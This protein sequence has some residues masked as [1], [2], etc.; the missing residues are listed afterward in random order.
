MMQEVFVRV[1]RN[2]DDFREDASP[3]TW[4]YRI[5]TNLCLNQIRDRKRQQEKLR[6]KGA[7]PAVDTSNTQDARLA[8]LRLLETVP[9]K[10]AE[11]ALYHYV[12][13]LSHQEVASLLGLPR[14]TVTNRIK[15]FDTVARAYLATTAKEATR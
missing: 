13:G 10:A 11:P 15:K 14:R 3:T 2:I 5:T 1:I 9:L 6:R 4:L 8:V 7:L 12:D